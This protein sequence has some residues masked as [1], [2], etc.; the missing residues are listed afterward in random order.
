MRILILGAAGMIGRKLSQRLGE[1]GTLAGRPISAA[2]L[3]DRVEPAAPPAPFPIETRAVDLAEPAVAA[4]LG[5]WRPDAVF[6]L[7]AIVSGEAEAD[8]DK[9]YA[10]NLDATRL[11]LEA[12]R[13]AGNA[14]RLVFASSLAVYGVPLPDVVPDDYAL[15]PRSSYGAQKAIGELLVADYA[16]KGFVDGLSFRLPTLVVRPGAPNRAASS[17]LSGIIREPID[18]IP[19]TIPVDRGMASWLA[20]PRIAVESLIHAAG[21]SP[22]DAASAR[23]LTG[24][25]ISVTVAEMMAALRDVAGPRAAALVTDAPDPAIERIVASWPRAFRCNAARR[26]GFPEDESIHAIIADYLAT[27]RGGRVAA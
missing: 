3:V 19:A 22:E 14:P 1:L 13:A 2:L 18:G 11:L 12:L 23:A 5:A 16:R 6:H 8:F 10:V 7:A 20:S 9:G 24:R 26:L 27:E 21:L 17:F 4:A 15:T 25:G